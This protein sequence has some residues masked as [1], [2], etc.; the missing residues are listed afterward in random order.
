MADKP[1]RRFCAMNQKL[2][3][4]IGRSQRLEILLAL[5]RHGGM[6]V[7]EMAAQF[8]MSYMGVKQHCL[9]LEKEGYLDTWR[10]PKGK[11]RPEMLYRLTR[12]AQDLFPGVSHSLTVEVLEAVQQ[13]YGPAAPTKLLF[14]IFNGRAEY[15]RHKIGFP[16]IV[17]RADTLAR[18]RDAEG[19]MAEFTRAAEAGPRFLQ[20]TEH[21]SPIEE[22][23]R[24]YPIVAR[25]ERELFERVLGCP[26]GREERCAPGVYACVFSIGPTVTAREALG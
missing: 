3:R 13:T 9:D 12:R 4:D 18:L 8:R 10:R 11:G 23:L 6:A 17:E 25:L 14:G 7:K 1:T 5:K 21:H 26:V 2:I 19:Y 22:I 15:Y 20:I 24:H 16:G